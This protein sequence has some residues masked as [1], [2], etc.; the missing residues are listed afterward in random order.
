MIG[1]SIK[2]PNILRTL[3]GF[4]CDIPGYQLGG[5]AVLVMERALCSLQEFR[6]VLVCHQPDRRPLPVAFKISDFGTSCNFSTPDQPGGN[7][8]NM[9]PEVLWCFNSTIGSDISCP[10]KDETFK[11]SFM[12]AINACALHAKHKD[13]RPTVPTI[14]ANLK[15]MGRDIADKHFV[16]MGVL[17]IT[18]FPQERW[19]PSK[20]LNLTR[21]QCL[22]QDCGNA[23]LPSAKI[24]SSI[25]VGEYKPTDVIVSD[26]CVPEGLAELVTARSVTSSPVTVI[27]SDLKMY[28]GIDMF[29]LA[30]DLIQPYSWYSKKVKELEDVY[31]RRNNKRKAC[32]PVDTVKCVKPSSRITADN[33]SFGVCSRENRG[34]NRPVVPDVTKTINRDDKLL[35]VRPGETHGTESVVGNC[36]ASDVSL[37]NVKNNDLVQMLTCGNL[38]NE[39]PSSS[40]SNSKTTEK[41]DPNEA[42]V[43][44][45]DS[46]GS[47]VGSPIH[48]ETPMKHV[49]A[50]QPVRE[51]NI[52]PVPNAGDEPQG[53][54]SIRGKKIKGEI[55]TT[56]VILKSQ[57]EREIA[58]FKEKV[59]LLSQTVTQ[60][61]PLIFEGPRDGLC[62]CSRRKDTFIFQYAQFF[63]GHQQVDNWTVAD[64]PN[65][66]YAFLLQVLLTLKAALDINLLPT[67]MTE[68]RNV[69]IGK[70]A[71]MIDIVPYLSR[72]FNKPQPMFGDHCKSLTSLCATMVSI[73]LPESNLANWLCKL[74]IETPA[75]H[76]LSKSIQWLTEVS[77][78]EFG[79]RTTP[80]LLSLHGNFFTFKDYSCGMSNWLTHAGEEEEAGNRSTSKQLV[81]GDPKPARDCTQGLTVVTLSN[82][83]LSGV[84]SVDQLCRLASNCFAHD[85]VSQTESKW[86]PVI[87]FTK[88]RRPGPVQEFSVDYYKITI[89]VVLLNPQGS[90]RSL[91]QLF[92]S[93]GTF[94]VTE[95]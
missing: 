22:S 6:N 75:C 31:K 7:R 78:F 82:S 23:Q 1:V 25:Q 85:A 49:Y 57:N 92:Q 26:D 89:L 51:P 13:R 59:I 33:G 9:A 18:L 37:I 76:V 87:K 16:S 40:H 70:G 84:P 79:E 12:T 65:S 20:L 24:P 95:Y 29:R 64:S 91:G 74:N 93:M 15:H 38:G 8:T 28:Y 66:I 88:V 21:Y 55:D 58:R 17:C 19:S 44:T 47:G 41:N 46:L 45:D 69:L 52:E 68:W 14:L 35:P 90:V 27:K 48:A 54:V 73:H 63:E 80:Q 62:K 67:H 39:M 81:Y 43:T 5:R 53:L 77:E 83:A 3:G 42:L 30:P 32:N 56:M 34:P 4:W 11:C 50:P 72:N 36:M 71:V 94:S 86:A 60:R 61:Q 10:E 2:H